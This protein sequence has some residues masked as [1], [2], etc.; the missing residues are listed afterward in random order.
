L[1]WRHHHGCYDQAYISTAELLQA[2]DVWIANKLRP[3]PHRRDIA[4]MKRVR[5]GGM[6]RHCIWT[7]KPVARQAVGNTDY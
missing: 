7:E 5:D 3:K 2:E 6:I 1:C 4:M